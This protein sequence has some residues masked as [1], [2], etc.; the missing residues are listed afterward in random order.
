MTKISPLFRHNRNLLRRSPATFVDAFETREAAGR[1]AGM[2]ATD[3]RTGSMRCRVSLTVMLLCLVSAPSASAYTPDDPVVQQM[4]D[5]GLKALEAMDASTSER[6]GVPM[7]MGYAHHKCQHDPDNPVVKKGIAAAQRYV[8]AMEATGTYEH[9]AMYD[10]SVCILLFAEVDAARYR[11]EMVSLQK[12]L[13]DSQFPGGGF[14]YHGGTQG[15]VSQ[16][17][18]VVLAIWTLDRNGIPLDYD[19]VVACL[20]WLLRVQDI[21]GAWPYTGIDPGPGKP[22]IRQTIGVGYSMALAGG[23]SILIAGDALRL[24]GDTG[25]DESDPGVVGL[26]EAIKLYLEDG[27]E[28]RRKKVKISQDPIFRAIGFLEAWRE[29][30][31]Q[32]SGS[33]L[34]LLHHLHDGAVRELYRDRSRIGQGRQ[35]RLVQRASR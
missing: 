5:R 16:V 9:K 26:P 23:S 30:S 17:Q 10:I 15:D 4:V 21:E 8:K 32:T 11:D 13:M 28:N 27:N 12:F 18:Y 19:K 20:Q 33:G 2:V 22:N 29:E 14:G 3:H 31:L 1:S 24:W 35:P 34:V 7:L 6:A 25:S